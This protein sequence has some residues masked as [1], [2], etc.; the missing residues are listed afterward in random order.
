[1]H[2]WNMHKLVAEL[3][4]GEMTEWQR[5]RYLL[6]FFVLSVLWGMIQ[7]LTG[8][9]GSSLRPAEALVIGAIVLAI[10]IFGF[11]QV[12]RLNKRNGETNFVERAVCLSLPA[13]IRATVITWA[14]MGAMALL[15]ARFDWAFY[16]I[17]FAGYIAAILANLLFFWFMYDA[18]KQ[19]KS[20][21]S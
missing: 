10:N 18:F 9:T 17:P 13:S 14:S 16:V 2:L 15:L 6:G 11:I 21:A 7:S 20:A 5:A 19:F 12:F 3:R 4:S 8:G 1:M